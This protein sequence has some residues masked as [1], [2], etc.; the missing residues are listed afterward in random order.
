MKKLILVSLVGLLG[1]TSEAQTYT[2]NS[3]YVGCVTKSAFDKYMKYAVAKDYAA[4]ATLEKNNLCFSLKA[5][6]TVYVE[7]TSW[8]KVEIRP[9]GL[10]GT[11]WTVM[12]AIKRN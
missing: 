3:G 2:T 7:D 4:V 6:V 8:G 9:K 12:E 11:I 10:T 1:L 5:G